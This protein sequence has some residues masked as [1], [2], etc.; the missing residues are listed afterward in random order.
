MTLFCDLIISFLIT[1]RE[2]TSYSLCSSKDQNKQFRSA[3]I[4]GRNPFADLAFYTHGTEKKKKLI[5]CIWFTK[6]FVSPQD[7]LPDSVLFQV[8]QREHAKLKPW[9]MKHKSYYCMYRLILP[10]CIFTF[11]FFRYVG[12]IHWHCP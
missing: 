10:A 12:C 9:E 2:L 3:K 8:L 5:Q 6:R 1:G 11:V 7:L 4:Q